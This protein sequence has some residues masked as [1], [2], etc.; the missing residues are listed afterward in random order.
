MTFKSLSKEMAYY[1]N[2]VKNEK[3]QYYYENAKE[4]NARKRKETVANAKSTST[5]AI[6]KRKSRANAAEQKRNEK[7]RNRLYSKKFKAKLTVNENEQVCV[8][9]NRMEKCRL[10]K[11]IR[12][13]IPGTP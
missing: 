3:M 4:I 1:L 2:K 11:K 7:E 8:F 13:I 5:A 12:D 10:L 9:K 6:R